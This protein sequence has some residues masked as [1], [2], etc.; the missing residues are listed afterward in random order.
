MMQ[1]LVMLYLGGRMALSPAEFR[2]FIRRSFE[3]Y[4]NGIRA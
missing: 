1:G 2:A 4:L 3:R